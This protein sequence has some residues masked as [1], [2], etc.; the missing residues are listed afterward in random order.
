MPSK[1]TSPT[2]KCCIIGSCGVGKTSIIHKYM[3]KKSQNTETTL[4]AIFWTFE[5]E[6]DEGYRYKIDFWDTAGQERYNSLIPMYSRNSDIIII[7]FDIAD[8]QTFLDVEKWLE[9]VT[10]KSNNSNLILVGNKSDMGIIADPM[11]PNECSMP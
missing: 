2:V 5:K 10:E 9:T 3:G 7:A 8:R 4:G 11:I 6:T 1:N